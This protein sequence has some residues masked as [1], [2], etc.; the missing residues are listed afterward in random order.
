MAE[1]PEEQAKRIQAA[2]EAAQAKTGV[3]FLPVKDDDEP[4]FILRAQDLISVMVLHEYLRLLE[5][6]DPH[7]E[8]MVSAVDKMNEFRKWQHANPSRVRLPD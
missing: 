6:F 1:T 2:H 8:K 3:K 7:G 4:V 5:I